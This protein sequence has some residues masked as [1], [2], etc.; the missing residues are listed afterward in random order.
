MIE[1]G[2]LV[3]CPIETDQE[4]DVNLPDARIA[5]GAPLQAT[6]RE[7]QLVRIIAV[8]AQG[9]VIDMRAWEGQPCRPVSAENL[10]QCKIVLTDAGHE[11]ISTSRSRPRPVRQTAPFDALGPDPC[12]VPEQPPCLWPV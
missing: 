8:K 11:M 3:Y 6:W 12:F 5:P 4:P 1:R 2:L 10:S 7:D 9:A